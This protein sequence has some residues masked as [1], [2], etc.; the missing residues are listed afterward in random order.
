MARNDKMTDVHNQSSRT[1]T[2]PSGIH[3]E[4][5]HTEALPNS[6]AAILM[7]NYPRDLISP[8]SLRSAPA[9]QSDTDR[10]KEIERL[11]NVV[12][13]LETKLAASVAEAG[14]QAKEVADPLGA[15]FG[16]LGQLVAS[17]AHKEALKAGDE[18]HKAVAM[19]HDFLADHF[20]K[21]PPKASS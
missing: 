7:K 1:Y 6:E 9:S 21:N 15:S 2:S 5:G 4:P 16:F 18:L 12:S 14:K 17:E 11:Q 8:D 19:F 20:K 10:R 13:D 3:I